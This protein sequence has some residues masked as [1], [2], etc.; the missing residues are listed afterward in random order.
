[1]SVIPDHDRGELKNVYR[2]GAFA[3]AV[4]VGVT[5]LCA[6]MFFL[7]VVPSNAAT[8]QGGNTTQ[9]T[10]SQTIAPS[11][12]LIY[13]ADGT[14]LVK[15]V[16]DLSVTVTPS[17]LPLDQEPIVAAR[18]GSI[19]NLDPD[20]IQKEIDSKT[21]SQYLPVKIADGVAD[22]VARF[23]E[24]NAD[25][26]PGVKVVVASKRQY[27]NKQFAEI[28]G[29]EG[30][31]TAQQYALLKNQGYSD[32]DIVGQAGLEN[33]YEQQLRGT[34]GTETVALD[35]NGK[36]IPGLVTPVKAAVPGDSLTLN[37]DPKEQAYAT[38][39]LQ[40]L[41]T[42]AKLNKGV[43]IVENPQ[44]GKILA[45]VSLPS[46]DNQLFADGIS[47]T[48]FQALLSS[49]DQPLANKA[50]GAQYAPG[51][52]FKLVT[53]TAGLVAGP[54]LNVCTLVAPSTPAACEQPAGTT[55]VPSLLPSIDTTSTFVSQAYVQIGEYKYWE[56]NKQGW[57]PLNIF[58][59]VSYSSDTFFYQLSEAVGLTK[60]TYWA[61]QYGFGKP[62]GVDLPEPATGI[63]PTDAWALAN[64]GTKMYEGELMQAGIGQGYDA[65]TPLQLL[66]AYCALA[67]GGTVWQPQIVKSITSTTADGR[68]VV[69]NVQPVAMNHLHTQDGT[70]INPA[71]LETMRLG[72]RQVVTS[73]HTGNLVDMQ[74]PVA[75]KTGTAEF[76][77]PDRFGVLPYHEWF[78]GYVPGNLD[79]PDW[80]KP[81]SP[82]AVLAFIYGANTWGNVA[83]EVVK[84]YMMLHYGVIRREDSAFDFR[85]PGYILPYVT[86]RT[87]FYGAPARD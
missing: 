6:R 81:D 35:A 24:E 2:F 23:I 30:Q 75:G 57:G 26:L 25:A 28:V 18:L 69:T 55:A 43:I 59:G 22:N 33:S 76:G 53:G 29:Y 83:T 51:S 8:G 71:V 40:S 34:P 80:S 61:D 11:R 7:Q 45:M 68:T 4:I 21:G 72:M 20:I 67:N 46:Y 32:S 31:I 42:K 77:V 44:N 13:A 65:S 19:L 3:L 82:L 73:R 48:D 16:V 12:G 15:N 10:Q 56:W 38:L 9:T 62:T 36:P 14:P 1:M 52:T 85:T 27:L 74:I 47:D 5:T 78:V 50:V 39:A 66:N 17:D 60:L 58:G 37:I 63:V 49:P 70:P 54:P 84:N 79:S 41:L 87:N 64:H 86:K